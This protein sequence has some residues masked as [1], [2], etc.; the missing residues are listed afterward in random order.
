MDAA[1]F[2]KDLIRPDSSGNPVLRNSNL[3]LIH[4][5]ILEY[6]QTVLHMSLPAN[7][8]LLP[9]YDDQALMQLVEKVLG[10]AVLGPHKKQYIEMII[11][12]P[13]EVQAEL[14]PVVSRILESQENGGDIGSD[15]SAP[16]TPQQN[17]FGSS[18]QMVSRE[19]E[20]ASELEELRGEL[21]NVQNSQEAL[22]K[23]SRMLERERDELAELVA[24]LEKKLEE[25]TSQSNQGKDTAGNFGSIAGDGP[26][27]GTN[28]DVA[29]SQ[30]TM[31]LAARAKHEEKVLELEFIIREREDALAEVKQRAAELPRL[32]N[33]N[34]TLRDE[35]DMLQDSANQAA[36]AEASLAKMKKRLED[37]AALKVQITHLEEENHRYLQKTLDLEEENRK[38]DVLKSQVEQYKDRLNS[39]VAR[40]STLTV[41]L[42]TAETSLAAVT[43]QLNQAQQDAAQWKR[44]SDRLR[45]QLA[46]AEMEDVEESVASHMNMAEESD[47]AGHSALK[48]KVLRLERELSR[49]RVAT[50]P[51]QTGASTAAG[52]AEGESESESVANLKLELES[53]QQLRAKFEKCYTDA[54]SENKTLLGK[55]RSIENERFDIDLKV[56]E[57][58]I[59]MEKM[60]QLEHELA[61]CRMKLNATEKERDGFSH[62]MEIKARGLRHTQEEVVVLKQ[63]LSL[64]G[65]EKEEGLTQ[66]V[67]KQNSDVAAK[68]ESLTKQLEAKVDEVGSLNNSVSDLNADLQKVRTELDAS[69]KEVSNL[70]AENNKVLKDKDAL[71]SQ[72]AEVEREF[73]A[74]R[75]SLKEKELEIK[76]RDTE[77][78]HQKEMMATVQKRSEE[79]IEQ[80]KESGGERRAD[81]QVKIVE[82]DSE[83]QDLRRQ[84]HENTATLKDD[85]ERAQAQEVHLKEQVT[86]FHSENTELREHYFELKKKHNELGGKYNDLLERANQTTNISSDELVRLES[87]LRESQSTVERLRAETR[88]QKQE[89]HLISSAFYE[90][91]IA[92]QAARTNM[93][94]SKHNTSPKTSFLSERRQQQKQR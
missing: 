48:E 15:H 64:L 43:D 76:G 19:D 68:M 94:V 18:H 74:T 79:L 33:E 4:K 81:F 59:T 54:V 51:S 10:I 44:D 34:R 85:L 30:H 50:P 14:M 5:S 55:I 63:K 77:L 47:M 86:S 46:A 17:M 28:S 72:L 8:V 53:A 16:V 36:K 1:Y 75:L 39:V 82:K 31:S 66:L 60:R 26:D 35:L 37:V 9:S 13:P 3:Q 38:M 24:S 92:L 88:S 40:E 69:R 32:Q 23:K 25:S 7:S 87:A 22:M 29:S 93:S 27:D 11:A 45:D 12:L 49:L 2:P 42:K 58:S 71:R 78:A 83:I 57:A 73:S 91:G 52:S 80:L 20:D 90:M 41:E 21:K 70:I 56:S 67:E 89:A 65:H 61:E 6:Y 84:L 62:E